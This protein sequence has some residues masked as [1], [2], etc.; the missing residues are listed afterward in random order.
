MRG[1]GKM[2]NIPDLCLNIYMR[3]SQI[4]LLCGKELQSQIKWVT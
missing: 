3:S 4:F 2:E 1:E